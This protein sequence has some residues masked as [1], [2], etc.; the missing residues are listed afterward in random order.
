MST[1]ARVALL[2]L[3]AAARELHVPACR[4]VSG[5][6]LAAGCDPG[7]DR[8]RWLAGEGVGA[9]YESAAALLAAERPDL[10]IVAA[11]PETHRELVMLALAQGAHVL[12]E[13]PLAPSVAD[14]D[15]MI[16]AAERARRALAVNHEYPH[17]AIYREALAR[18]GAGEY[19][20][21]YL[22]QCWQHMD[23]GAGAPAGWRSAPGPYT[24]LEFGPHALDL[25][26]RFLGAW[27]EAVTAATAR[28]AGAPMDDAVVTATLRFPGGPLASVVLNRAGR[29]RARY[30][31][32]RVDCERASLRLSLGGLAR[33][34]V[35]LA[36]GRRWPAARLTLVRGGEA[37]VESGTRS[38]VLAVERREGRPAATAA[39]LRALVE[40]IGRGHAPTGEA[41]RAR[42]VLR[43]VEAAY[44]SAKTGETVWLRPAMP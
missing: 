20:A 26:C 37:R 39:V 16:A 35:D 1:G 21:P 3:G 14:A 10:A 15:E 6:I 5:V 36:R 9:V 40:A 28:A 32:M 2:G 25:V 13:K 30:F 41:R 7:P 8:R 22:V 19:G 24:L 33:A 43:I 23:H 17:L 27:P 44:A 29:G 12:C 42:E 31:E 38:R 11:P 18:V 34:S 4:A